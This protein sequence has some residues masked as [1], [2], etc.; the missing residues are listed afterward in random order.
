MEQKTLKKLCK[1]GTAAKV[2]FIRKQT[3]GYPEYFS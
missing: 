1:E 3:N 2:P